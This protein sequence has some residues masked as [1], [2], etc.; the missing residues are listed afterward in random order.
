VRPLYA[1]PPTLIA[2]SGSGPHWLSPGSTRRKAMTRA[3]EA[4]FDRLHGN[5][6]ARLAY[7]T[8]PSKLK[9]VGRTWA[10]ALAAGLKNRFQSAG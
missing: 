3:Q 5:V 8:V 4:L 7:S 9:A 10:A 2:T 1:V 6:M